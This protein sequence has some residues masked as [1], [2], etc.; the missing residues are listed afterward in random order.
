MQEVEGEKIVAVVEHKSEL[1]DKS[2]LSAATTPV[3]PEQDV[4]ST[5]DSQG[6]DPTKSIASDYVE[7]TPKKKNGSKASKSN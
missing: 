3:E 1:K 5:D 2:E 7:E 4:P 6:T